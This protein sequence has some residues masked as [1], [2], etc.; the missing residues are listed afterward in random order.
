MA[1]DATMD[2]ALSAIT[3]YYNP[4]SDLVKQTAVNAAVD[5]A[6]DIAESKLYLDGPNSQNH[7]A[8]AG[9]AKRTAGVKKGTRYYAQ[10][11]VG[12][13]LG[14]HRIM[15]QKIRRSPLLPLCGV[16]LGIIT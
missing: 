15:G 9:T 14:H 13:L 5:G 7:A 4:I 11:K 1:V 6:L 16:A 3:Y 8:T 10:R 2:M 12:I